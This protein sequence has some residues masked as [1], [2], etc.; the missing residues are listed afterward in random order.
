MSTP[1]LVR[2]ERIRAFSARAALGLLVL[3]GSMGVDLSETAGSPAGDRA[4][5]R[6]ATTLDAASGPQ[7]S[8]GD[9]AC[10]FAGRYGVEPVA[11]L[12]LNRLDLPVDAPLPTGRRLA[13]P[14]DIPARY[15]VRPGDTLTSIARYFGVTTEALAERNGLENT[16]QLRA[17]ALLFIPPGAWTACDRRPA[18]STAPPPP[19]PTT[20]AALDRS[21]APEERDRSSSPQT[22]PQTGPETRPPVPARKLPDPSRS[23]ET[24]SLEIPDPSPS[25]EASAAIPTPEAISPPIEAMRSQEALE[26]ARTATRV[27]EDRYQS[28][29]FL[30]ALALVGVARHILAPLAAGKSEAGLAARASWISG[31]ALVGLG[32]NTEAIEEFRRALELDPSL[33]M[34]PDLSPKIATLVETA[35]ARLP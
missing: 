32:R 7:V 11:L 2:R 18:D 10:R 14:V 19:P 22:G 5:P 30:Q 8:P 25:H 21:T 31:Q 23:A 6:A 17:G 16:N 26:H 12:V 4:G 33:A 29:D 3:C 13:I 1:R 24:Q 20:Q 9:T 28:G 34:T 27:A 15:S 35:Q